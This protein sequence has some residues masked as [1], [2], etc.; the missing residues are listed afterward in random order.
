MTRYILL[1]A[2]LLAAVG[3]A[4]VFEVE[5]DKPLWFGRKGSVEFG[6]TG[7]SFQPPGKKAE[8]V[9]W[10]YRDIQFFDRVSRKEFRL[11]SYEDVAWKLGRDRGYDFEI[12]SGELSDALFEQV[13]ARI[14]K[15]ATDRVVVEPANVQQE[16]PAKHI[17]TLGGSQGTLYFA[18]ERI[19]YS[20]EAE[21]R[22]RE[23]ILDR[24]IHSVWSSDPYRLEVHAYEG[25]PG[26]FR[27]PRVYKFAL[28]QPLDAEF[29]RGL[30]L[31]LYEIDRRRDLRP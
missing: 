27:K 25:N 4:Q 8:T 3:A 1:L 20:S 11:L 12:T 24:D 22:S 26:A 17:T 9:S 15:P 16:L 28:K 5:I 7:I 21:E 18:P 2:H 23:W 19:V 10:A 14:G 30:K 13:T 6:D 31:R 29:Y